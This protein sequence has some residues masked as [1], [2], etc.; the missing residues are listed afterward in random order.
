MTE[1]IFANEGSLESTWRDLSFGIIFE[2]I[3]HEILISS[4]VY[5]S[6]VRPK[7]EQTAKL[8]LLTP[9]QD[10]TEYLKHIS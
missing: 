4:T 8:W 3:G 1:P 5:E 7:I 9:S 6:S 10:Y 2:S